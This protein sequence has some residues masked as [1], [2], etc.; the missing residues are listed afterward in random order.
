[1]KILDQKD[2][3][4]VQ[5]SSPLLLETLR[6]HFELSKTRLETLAVLL[7]GLANT[8][9]VNLSH[10]ASQFPGAALHNSNYRSLQRFFQ[11]VRLDEDTAARLIARMLNLLDRPQLLALDR[12]NWKLVGIDGREHAGSSGGDAPVQDTA[13]VDAAVPRS[14]SQIARKAGRQGQRTS[15]HR[16]RSAGLNRVLRPASGR[17][18]TAAQ[19]GVNRCDLVHSARLKASLNI[20][21]GVD[22]PDGI[23]LCQ[24][25]VVEDLKRGSRP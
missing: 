9:T 4:D 8:R 21:V 23:V 19:V 5:P 1:M 11:H 13:D 15:C 20:C 17:R 2:L 18:S 3:R 16:W 14:T 6:P 24:S 7:V 12:T 25:E 10:L 22:G